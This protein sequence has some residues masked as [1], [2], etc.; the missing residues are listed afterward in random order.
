MPSIAEQECTPHTEPVSYAMMNAV[1]RKPIQ[2]C[3]PDAQQLFGTGTHV[4][5]LRMFDAV[6]HKT[7]QALR[8]AL[9]RRQPQRK[10]S[11]T[12]RKVKI[13]PG[14]RRFEPDVGDV[15]KVFV[16]ASIKSSVN[17]FPNLATRAVA[18]A[19][20]LD[21]CSLFVSVP[22]K[23]DVSGVIVLIEGNQNRAALN[24]CASL[25]KLGN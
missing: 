25:F 9:A 12:C 15:I 1:R 19:H 11:D 20:I 17:A 7:Y 23:Y 10:S 2:I 16:R 6:R 8:Q 22:L 3:Y 21:P 13:V 24:L 18:T 4:V 5:K 14:I